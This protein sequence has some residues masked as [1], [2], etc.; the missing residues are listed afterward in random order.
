MTIT[1]AAE[2]ACALC[3]QALYS[4]GW[5]LPHHEVS[6]AS[7]G[8][9]ASGKSQLGP[10]GRFFAMTWASC[11]AIVTAAAGGFDGSI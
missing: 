4:E 5:H 7:S 2:C 11:C 6:Y 10:T 3:V 8:A 9:G 1:S